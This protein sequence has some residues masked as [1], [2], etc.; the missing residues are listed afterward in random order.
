MAQ[1]KPEEKVTVDQV[2]KL[3]DQ[4]SP[5]EQGKLRHKLAESWS[6]E[7]RA[8][9]KEVDEQNKGTPPLSEEEIMAEV[10]DVR[11]EMKA[12]RARQSSR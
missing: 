11:E 12:E 7:W 10:K 9:L 6:M 3:V 1:R 5:E 2:L 8:L 4:L